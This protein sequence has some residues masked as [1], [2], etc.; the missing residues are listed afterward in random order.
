MVLSQASSHIVPGE[1]Y[2]KDQLCSLPGVG[3]GCMPSG[4]VKYS[5][6]S[7]TSI[8]AHLWRDTGLLKAAYWPHNTACT[9]VIV[10]SPWFE[11]NRLVCRHVVFVLSFGVSALRGLTWLTKYSSAKEAKMKELSM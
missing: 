4:P 1:H 3:E 2:N 7:T 10:A 8:V 5:D 11:I 9:N 6:G